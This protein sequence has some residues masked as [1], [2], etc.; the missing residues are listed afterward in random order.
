MKFSFRD[1]SIKD[2]L[3]FIILFTSGFVLLLAAVAFA[4]NEIYSFRRAM[5]ADLI[6]VAE[7]IGTNSSAGLLF[8]DQRTVEENMRGLK[9]KPNLITTVVFDS[10]GERFAGYLRQHEKAPLAEDVRLADLY[11]EDAAG[12]AEKVGEHFVFRGDRV[13]VFKPIVFDGDRLGTVYIQSDLLAL[14]DRLIWFAGVV[15]VVVFVALIFAFLL[16]SRL[17]ALITTPIFGLLAIMQQ[18]SVDKNYT[19]RQPKT[20]DDELGKLVE[21][22]NHMLA[23]IETRDRELSQ[24][25]YHLEELVTRRTKELEEARDQALAANKAKSIFLA[26]MSHEIR[27]PMNAVLGYAQILQR[28]TELTQEQR[29]SLRIIENSGNHLLGLINDILDISKIEAGAMELRADNFVLAELVKG[30]SAMF[31]IRCAQK[32]LNWRV[33]STIPE[34]AVVLADQ[35]KLRQIFINLLGNAVK[36]TD[37]GEVVFRVQ[38]RGDGRCQFD[39]IDTGRGIPEEAHDSIFEPFQQEREGFD[40]GG[41]GLGL[42]ITKR[43]VEMMN[44]TI[45]V[46]SELGQGACFTVL[47]TLPEGDSDGMVLEEDAPEVKC[48]AE[49]YSVHAL[50]IDDVK[51]NRDI[52]AHIL[53]NIGVRVT[54]AIHGQEALDQLQVE[55]PDILFSDIR[56]PVMD[57]MEMI[58]ELKRQYPEG[59]PPCVAITASTLHHQC[60]IILDAGF[61]DFISKPFRFHEIWTCLGKHL[62][63]EFVYESEAGEDAAAAEAEAA[64]PAKEVALSDITLAKDLYDRLKDAAELNE[65]TELEEMIAEMRDGDD[66]VRLLA[67]KFQQSLAE[68]DVDGILE[69]LEQ[70]RYG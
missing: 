18:V 43:Q 33:E 15:M 51:E 5:V 2:K 56:M 57:G 28:D 20:G 52:L 62:E 49:G 25:H 6:S 27:T 10:A 12:D 64:A 1:I 7:I 63:V 35:G 69:A 44:G 68:Y 67:E 42:A 55:M 70:V 47:I 16:A 32:G 13:E 19:L 66:N 45:T 31:K 50:V 65:L 54:Q 17:Q 48:L 26:N 34:N 11:F 41:T 59:H 21:G 46:A 22:F 3:R 40:K 39:I 38:S 4:T 61:D 37:Q 8:S 23:Q 14:R 24:Y 36:F 60:Q 9:A 58:A 29:E 53:E 30:I